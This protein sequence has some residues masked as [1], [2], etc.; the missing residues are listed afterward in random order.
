MPVEGTPASSISRRLFFIVAD[1]PIV[2]NEKFFVPKLLTLE[3]NLHFEQPGA[4]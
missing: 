2:V 1:K 4:L 3:N